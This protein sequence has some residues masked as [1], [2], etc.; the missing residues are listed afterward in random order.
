M[1]I[2]QIAPLIESVPPALYGGTERV[3]AYLTDELVELGH[4]VTLF[5]SGDSKTRAE[6]AAIVPHSLRLDPQVQE[7]LPY[8]CIQADR[9]MRRAHEFDIVHFHVDLIHYVY[10]RSISSRM[11]TTLH[12]RLDLPDLQRFYRHFPHFPLVSISD[13]QRA[14]MPPVNWLATVQHGIPR[15][16]LRFAPEP[17]K[18][19]AFLG[20]LSR[21]KRPDRAI[22]IAEATGV[23]LKI[24]AKVDRADRDY[25][26][27]EIKPL[28]QSPLV[29]WI[30]EIN[31]RDK[32]AF[33]GGACALL[34]PVDWPE[35]FGLVLI[36][37]MACGTPVIAFRCGSVPEIVEP[38]IT[39]FIVDNMQEAV[40]AAWRVGEL[41]RERIRQRFEERFTSE[42]M[43]QD[44][45]A[46]YESFIS[47]AQPRLAAV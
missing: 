30:G 32:S 45:A 5:A 22:R 13:S 8:A 37:A 26:E 36:E 20:R 21:E 40:A 2:A 17:G 14:P 25:F 28:L 16:L 12:G 15:D 31:D 43:A 9:V 29:E 34:F 11:L 24:A 44:Y 39:G 41:N 4:K 27:S 33:L 3:V 6:L 23:P 1:R 38:G 47:G 42:R 7:Y 10:A 35:P 46:I 18:Y 19:F